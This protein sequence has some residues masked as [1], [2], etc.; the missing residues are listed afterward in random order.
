M[1]LT[2]DRT[3]LAARTE[4]AIAREPLFATR[5]DFADPFRALV[6]TLADIFES[7]ACVSI[8]DLF[9]GADDGDGERDGYAQWNEEAA[10]VRH[11]ERDR[12]DCGDDDYA[13]YD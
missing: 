10:L 6:A 7:P 13:D 9:P 8:D 5:P 3:D 1:N 4:T 12:D 2:F 11:A